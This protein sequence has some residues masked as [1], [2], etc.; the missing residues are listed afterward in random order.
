MKI[1]DTILSFILPRK[2]YRHHRMRFIFSL[3]LFICSTL[4]ILFSVNTSTKKFIKKL[5]PTTEVSNSIYNSSKIEVPNYSIIETPDGEVILDCNIESNVE[6][7]VNGY[8]NVFHDEISK[9]DGTGV[10]DL[11][12][13]FIEDMNTLK[14]TQE[15][16][17]VEMSKLKSVFDFDSYMNQ[18]CSDTKEYLLYIFTRN[19]FYYCFNLGKVKDK[20]GVWVD[21]P[22]VFQITSYEYDT[23]SN[24]NIYYLP[25]SSEQLVKSEQFPDQWD[26][27]KWTNM[28]SSSDTFEYNGEVIHA[29]KKFN[30]NIRHIL[31]KGEYMYN[32]VDYSLINSTENPVNFSKNTDKLSVISGMYDIMVDVDTNI[33]KSLYSFFTL[34]SNLILPLVFVLI[35]WLLSKNFVLSKFKEYYAICSIIYLVVSIIGFGLGFLIPFDKLIFI[36]II[37]ELLYYIIAT[38][39]INSDQALLDE[40]AENGEEAKQPGIIKPKMKFTKIESDDSYHIE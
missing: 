27:S 36:L 13:V 22:N 10:L 34:I 4:I 11:T 1:K 24:Q 6:G 25:A 39:R 5:I 30:N 8:R 29:K 2:M 21:N 33:Q 14:T 3:G 20:A 26:T 19:S 35:T 23:A 7:V 28:V 18:Q 38:F 40:A 32:S 12:I 9:K 16:I 31:F 37:V 17:A 15:E